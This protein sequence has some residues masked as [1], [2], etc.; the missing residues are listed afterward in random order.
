MAEKIDRSNDPEWLNKPLGEKGKFYSGK[1][2]DDRK[3]LHIGKKVY[4][5]TPK[6]N[7]KKKKGKKK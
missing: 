6:K 7:K 4:N 2:K 3:F 1:P 5:V